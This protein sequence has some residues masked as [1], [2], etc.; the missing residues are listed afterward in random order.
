MPNWF[1]GKCSAKEIG[2][3][4]QISQLVRSI[5]KCLFFQFYI[6]ECSMQLLFL[7]LAIF[8][9][10]L[11]GLVLYTLRQSAWYLEPF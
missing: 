10:L 5:A 2:S 9:Y 3:H 1:K 7:E 4:N 6:Y 8:L 11:I